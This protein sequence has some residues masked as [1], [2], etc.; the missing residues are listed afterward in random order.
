MINRGSWMS[1]SYQDISKQ[2]F[3]SYENRLG[4]FSDIRTLYAEGIFGIKKRH[5]TGLKI[6]SEQETSLFRKTSAA[7][8]Y[9]LG[10]ELSE[11]WEW[12][13][14]TDFS[15]INIYFGPSKSTA[16]GSAW[17]FNANLST[18]LLHE[19]FELGLGMNQIPH[20]SI[21]PINYSF[22]LESYYLGYALYKTTFRNFD[23]HTA[24]RTR[25]TD[26][27]RIYFDN[28][29]I[30]QNTAGLLLSISRKYQVGITYTHES[31]HTRYT[32]IMSYKGVLKSS[33]PGHNE[34]GIGVLVRGN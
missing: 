28:H 10:V 15:G 21:A 34:I 5:I 26:N 2:F 14:A 16:G 6:Y 11:Q 1:S 30:Y 9:S 23:I 13:V 7:W 20:Q 12:R 19:N 3:A 22:Q 29:I 4:L 8:T 24:L 27:L 32:F 33:I 31:I 18:S 25:Y 17:T